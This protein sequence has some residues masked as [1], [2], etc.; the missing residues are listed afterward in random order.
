VVRLDA[1]DR[2]T[3]NRPAAPLV[4]F[5]LTH[6]LRLTVQDTS[7]GVTIA[8]P[9]LV[10]PVVV[11]GDRFE[12]R[13]GQLKLA[14]AYGPEAIDLPLR[15]EAQYWNG[16][17]FVTNL[18]DNCTRF[19]ASDFA[20][21]GFRG[22]LSGCKAGVRMSGSG[23]LASGIGTVRILTGKVAGSVSIT[24]NLVGEGGIA[25]AGP[26]Q[27]RAG[28][29]TGAARPWLLGKWSGSDKYDR[30]PSSKVTFGIRHGAEKVIQIREVF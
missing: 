23:R 25:C 22:G 28:V 3:L 27:S 18:A 4:P 20:L 11:G 8:S 21:S 29:A 7:E 15:I 30:N 6:I 5:V 2:F 16:N 26:S 14:N 10:T 9:E 12:F 19:R 24:A 13:F 17:G 1:A